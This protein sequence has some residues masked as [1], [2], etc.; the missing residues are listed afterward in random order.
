MSPIEIIAYTGGEGMNKFG[1][2]DVL[3]GSVEELTQL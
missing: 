1:E 3:E 2:I